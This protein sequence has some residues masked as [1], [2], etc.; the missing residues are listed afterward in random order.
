MLGGTA[1]FVFLSSSTSTTASFSASQYNY[2]SGWSFGYP[3]TSTSTQVLGNFDDVHG[4]DFLFLT[5]E[6]IY[7]F[8]SNGDGTFTSSAH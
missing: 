5:K 8:L 4:T 6:V 1:A 2:T 7:S 3:P